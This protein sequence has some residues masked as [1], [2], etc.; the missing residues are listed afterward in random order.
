VIT[1]AAGSTTTAANA[2]SIAAMLSSFIV[3]SILASYG[4]LNARRSQ[5][6]NQSGQLLTNDSVVVDAVDQRDKRRCSS[7]R[8]RRPPAVSGA[9][10]PIEGRQALDGD[11]KGRKM[12]RRV[13]DA[14]CRAGFACA[15]NAAPIGSRLGC[16]ASPINFVIRVRPQLRSANTSATEA[17]A[18]QRNFALSTR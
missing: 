4:R 17:S 15:I 18:Q 5:P 7:W 11:D 1:A 13:A 3:V 10:D 8:T 14:P 12:K 2:Q 16:T 9:A 6:T